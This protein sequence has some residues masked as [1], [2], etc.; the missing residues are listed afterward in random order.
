MSGDLIRVIIADDHAVVRAGLRA[1][2]GSA[3]DI[4]V[5]GEAKTGV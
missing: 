1:V 5:I 4:E 2:L 3:K